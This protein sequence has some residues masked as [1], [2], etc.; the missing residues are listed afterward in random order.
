MSQRDD[1]VALRQMLDHARRAREAGAEK[2]E[3]ELRRDDLLAFALLYLIQTVGEAAKRVSDATRARHPEVP[4]QQISGMRNRIVHG[5]DDLDL[6][7]VVDVVQKDLPELIPALES[8]LA[9]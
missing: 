3:D 9:E 4:W 8:I 1:R 5:Y 6:A 2:S 7:I